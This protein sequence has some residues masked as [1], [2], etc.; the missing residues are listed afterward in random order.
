MEDASVLSAGRSDRGAEEVVRTRIKK[1]ARSRA[2]S[3]DEVSKLPLVCSS[4][5]LTF[6]CSG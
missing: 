2:N 4:C 1:K 5:M 6:V 3:D